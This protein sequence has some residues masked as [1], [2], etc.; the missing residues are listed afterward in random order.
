MTQTTAWNPNQYEKFKDQRAKPFIDLMNLIEP[1]KFTNAI[2]LGCGTGELTQKLFE[3]IKAVKMT[4]IDSSPEMLEKAQK[5]SAPPAFG[6]ELQDIGLF[7]PSQKQD[8][9]FSN[10]ALQWLPSHES[11]FPKIMSW[12]APD[13]QIAVQMPFNHEHPSHKIAD[14]VA[15][16]MYPQVFATSEPVH[17]LPIERYAEILHANGFQKQICRI[18]IYGHPMGSGNDVIEWTKGTLLNRYRAK[19]PTEDY[20]KFEAQYRKELL[21]V[22]DDGPYFYAFKRGLMWGRRA[23]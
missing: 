23:G 9:I 10:A 5:F 14:E 4:G 19:L 12:V 8:L 16:K 7:Q 15:R 2:D 22:I 3:H 18:E 21:S 1:A 20:A 13:G 11:L 6:F 17:V